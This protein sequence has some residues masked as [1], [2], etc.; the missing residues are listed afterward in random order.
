VPFSGI[1]AE[2][3]AGILLSNLAHF[4]SVLVLYSLSKS[5]TIV[6]KAGYMPF[7]ASTLH[8]LSPAGLFMSAP[9]AESL[10]SLFHISAMLAYCSSSRSPVDKHERHLKSDMYVLLSG[11][12]FA[13]ACTMRSNGLFSGI[14][15]AYDLFALIFRLMSAPATAQV[16]RNATA[17]VTA[18]VIVLVG[19]LYPQI[20]AYRQY[21]R[22]L[23]G[24]NPTWCN[25]LPPS[26]TTHVQSHY[27]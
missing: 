22:H 10:F 18:G 8:V 6:S 17:V 27:W 14:L 26:I 16:W 21:C 9:V 15:Y 12:L 11:A 4:L 7:I 19:F 3:V 25:A 23:H 20:A 1:Y 24:D 13:V 5:V 2:A